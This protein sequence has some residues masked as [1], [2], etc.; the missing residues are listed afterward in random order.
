M[1]GLG[2]FHT[3]SVKNCM[4]FETVENH[5]GYTVTHTMY[6]L[7]MERLLSAGLWRRLEL[8]MVLGAK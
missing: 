1:F 8:L 4:W 5:S 2:Q 3:T 6:V 7:Y